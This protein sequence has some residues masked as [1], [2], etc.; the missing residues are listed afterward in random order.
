MGDSVKQRCDKGQPILGR[1]QSVSIDS[2]RCMVIRLEQASWTKVSL[3][4]SG[5]DNIIT[6]LS[7][8][9]IQSSADI[10]LYFNISNKNK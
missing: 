9:M 1:N 7:A 4:F 6:I 8:G 5:K 2:R 3:I 10:L